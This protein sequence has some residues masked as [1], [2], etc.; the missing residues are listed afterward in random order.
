MIFLF[1]DPFSNE[2]L[3]LTQQQQKNRSNLFPYENNLKITKKNTFDFN[4]LI[5]VK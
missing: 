5:K 4:R 2:M 1:R 3:I